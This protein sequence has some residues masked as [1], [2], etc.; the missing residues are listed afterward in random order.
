MNLFIAWY[1]WKACLCSYSSSNGCEH[2]KMSTLWNKWEV[3]SNDATWTWWA[4]N[5]L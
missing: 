2:V 1:T 3:N 5:T 4:K